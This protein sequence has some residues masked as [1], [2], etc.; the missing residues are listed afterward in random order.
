ME[1]KPTTNSTQGLVTS[2]TAVTPQSIVDNKLPA[3]W[4]LAAQIQAVISKMTDKQLFLDIQGIK[5]H[6]D[7]PANLN[8]QVGDSLK[9][10]ITQL[11]PIPQF[12]IIAVLKKVD[13]VLINQNLRHMLSEKSSLAALFK[14]I[15]FV[16]TSPAIR[17]AP[18]HVEANN[19][20]REIFKNIPAPFN[21]KTANQLKNHILNSG[22]FLE[23]KINDALIKHPPATQTSTLGSTPMPLKQN[24]EQDLGA[25]LHRLANVLR[26]HLGA[27]NPAGKPSTPL[28]QNPPLS[29]QSQSPTAASTTDKTAIPLKQN[30][31]VV[32]KDNVASLQ[33]ITLRE[34]A[35]Q[36]FLRQVETSLTHLQQTQLQNL[37]D[38]Q[39]G[40]PMW[41]FELPIKDGN[42][43]DVFNIKINEEEE[44]QT[45]DRENKIWNVT[46]E[47]NFER[48][49]AI[50]SHIKL[51]GEHISAMFYSENSET[52]SLFD[53]NVELLRS[54]L[55]HNGL[56]IGNIECAKKEFS[57]EKTQVNFPPLDELT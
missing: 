35:M 12:R 27:F 54:R 23:H 53:K 26:S 17:P 38:S 31:S 28:T 37:N 11:N 25:L 7:K 4:Q 10:Q 40:R 1:I 13:N 48:L 8:L 45:E 49:G 52:L 5:S 51:Q 55:R 34:E 24:L 47:F 57:A 22:I 3:N 15:H 14:N 2:T 36:T 39:A 41:L 16:A 42:D 43:I 6:A 19:I 21:L 44:S 56:N 33:N 46:L 32:S 9:L 30:V 29:N 18:L 20:V 50:R